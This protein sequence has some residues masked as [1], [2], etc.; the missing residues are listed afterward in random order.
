[1][2]DKIWLEQNRKLK[3]FKDEEEDSYIFTAD[4]SN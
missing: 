3:D 2:K 4:E 1:M